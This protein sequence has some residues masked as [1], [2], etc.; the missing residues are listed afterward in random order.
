MKTE[1]FPIFC[2]HLLIII[3]VYIVIEIYILYTYIIIYILFWMT[4]ETL[5]LYGLYSNL[6]QQQDFMWLLNSSDAYDDGE[7]EEFCCSTARHILNFG[8]IGL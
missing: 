6:I 8:F 4:L 2:N 5:F 3:D 1:Y 7:F